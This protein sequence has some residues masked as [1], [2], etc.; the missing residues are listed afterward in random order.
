MRDFYQ[1]ALPLLTFLVDNTEHDEGTHKPKQHGAKGSKGKKDAKWHGAFE[2][3]RKDLGR[4]S[5][6]IRGKK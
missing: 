1:A 2:Q 6:F 3:R 4:V 5:R